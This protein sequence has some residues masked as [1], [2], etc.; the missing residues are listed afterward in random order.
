MNKGEIV[1]ALLELRTTVDRLIVDVSL[2]GSGDMKIP[3]TKSDE[4]WGRG[5]RLPQGYLS[6]WINKTY[7]TDGLL[8]SQAKMRWDFN[9]E[10]GAKISPSTMCQ[11]VHKEFPHRM[12]KG[13]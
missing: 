10:H 5:K 8:P 13:S 12:N 11:V 6:A 1:K 9:R 4:L 7:G 3:E 2:A